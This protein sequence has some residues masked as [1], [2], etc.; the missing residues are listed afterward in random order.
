MGVPGTEGGSAG[1]TGTGRAAQDRGAQSEGLGHTSVLT[2][3]QGFGRKDPRHL[4]H[5]D[6]GSAGWSGKGSHTQV[7]VAPRPA[8]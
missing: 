4:T 6:K 3:S 5:L 1:A 2:R 8:L 7:S